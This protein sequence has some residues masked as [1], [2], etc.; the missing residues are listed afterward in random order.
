MH[1][2]PLNSSNTIKDAIILGPVILLLLTFY[3]G[4]KY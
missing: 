1:Q 2:K 3:F 4:P